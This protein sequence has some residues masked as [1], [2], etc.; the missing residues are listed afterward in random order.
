MVIP[1][2][3]RATVAPSPTLVKTSEP[4]A[5]VNSSRTN[6]PRP[7]Q[8]APVITPSKEPVPVLTPAQVEERLTWF[9]NA[10]VPV[11]KRIDAIRDL[12][13]WFEEGRDF[14]V[15]LND[16]TPPESG[17]RE[18]T[19]SISPWIPQAE[20]HRNVVDVI[21]S[22]IYWL[23][24]GRDFDISFTPPDRFDVNLN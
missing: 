21:G 12:I 22:I 3:A 24:T 16:W 23:D 15:G 9:D 14:T 2:S 11:G 19:I 18:R 5:T 10:S 20:N 4:S 13:S 6:D 1:T 17:D 8:T 7:E